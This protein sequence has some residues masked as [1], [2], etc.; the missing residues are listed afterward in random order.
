ML[1]RTDK[2]RTSQ[3]KRVISHAKAVI[4]IGLDDSS[5]GVPWYRLD[6]RSPTLVEACSSHERNLVL[7]A[8]PGISKPAP[9]WLRFNRSLLD[10]LKA[11]ALE[12]PSLNA[13]SINSL[14]LEPSLV[15]AFSKLVV[16][17]FAAQFD[18][19]L[20]FSTKFNSTAFNS[21]AFNSTAFNSNHAALV[22]LARDGVLRA[23][24]TT[25]LDTMIEAAF[26]DAN[27]PLRT[28]TTKQDYQSGSENGGVC[29]LFRIHASEIYLSSLRDTVSRKT[30][31]LP[32]HVRARLASLFQKHH[33]LVVG[34]TGEDLEFGADYFAL[35]TTRYPN[36]GLTWMLAGCGDLSADV[37]P[38]E[39]QHRPRLLQ[40]LGSEREV[41]IQADFLHFCRSIDVGFAE[42][43]ESSQL[44]AND[45]R[46]SVTAWVQQIGVGPFAS[47]FFCARLLQENGT[48]L[49][50]YEVNNT[51]ERFLDDPLL[52]EFS[53]A[54]L[55]AF[56]A[57]NTTQQ[58]DVERLCNVALGLSPM[59]VTQGKD[60]WNRVRV[61][62]WSKLAWVYKT[63]DQPDEALSALRQA[64]A[65]AAA[66]GD[67]AMLS[68]LFFDEARLYQEPEPQ[69]GM[70][71]LAKLYDPRGRSPRT[72]WSR[73][74]EASAL[75]QLSEAKAAIRILEA[76]ILLR[77]GEVDRGYRHL[78]DILPELGAR[79]LAAY[80]RLNL[81]HM[82]EPAA[83]VREELIRELDW[84][85]E[86]AAENSVQPSDDIVPPPIPVA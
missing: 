23:I 61:A 62:V 5:E 40:K 31:G 67:S 59:V 1:N 80:V 70:Y 12:I 51:L 15:F 34:F 64:E 35:R 4:W 2:T 54:D 39:P 83:S 47:A 33:V 45:V 66:L 19:C 81:V 9:D 18:A 78:K 43:A 52:D 77:R 79:P 42:V 8:G 38:I 10:A 56:L 76:S 60:A 68:S 30:G 36:R 65:F 22:A 63:R 71:R 7:F 75:I 37:V 73:H 16:D 17:H 49:Q 48:R 86:Q 72:F 50:S 29:S 11:S 21:T 44:T 27:V 74:Y 84:L 82:F 57:Q 69:L 14:A 46:E 41:V 85:L 26:R 20:P 24:V 53:K 6:P 32:F 58:S 3:Y 55:A 13:E 28:Y 25:N